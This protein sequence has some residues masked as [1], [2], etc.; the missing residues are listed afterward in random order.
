MQGL[1]KQNQ[2]TTNLLTEVIPESFL[3]QHSG[4]WKAE[5][6]FSEGTGPSRFEALFTKRLVAFLHRA[7][8]Y[9]KPT[10]QARGPGP[11]RGPAS[12]APSQ[13]RA[14]VFTV[15]ARTKGC[16]KRA[17]GTEPAPEPVPPAPPAP[18]RGRAA[19]PQRPARPA[20]PPRSPSACGRIALP[21]RLPGWPLPLQPPARR[22]LPQ[23][24]NGAER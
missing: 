5:R 1:I 3:T 21:S 13:S 17:A 16:G 2:T 7:H 4:D 24:E 12:Q 14:D 10:D 11:L 22:F 20:G 18:S 9:F 19:S 15:P 23:F 6:T 8:R